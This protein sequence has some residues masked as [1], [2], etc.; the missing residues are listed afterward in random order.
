[1]S[2]SRGTN[3]R[4]SQFLLFVLIGVGATIVFSV[5]VAL[6]MGDFSA[7]GL[8]HVAKIMT[9]M[10][11]APAYIAALITLVKPDLDDAINWS[12]G[13]YYGGAV[14]AGV[15][16][17]FGCDDSP[18]A[19][20]GGYASALLIVYLYV[21]HEKKEEAEKEEHFRKW[22]LEKENERLKEEL[23]QLKEGKDPGAG[24]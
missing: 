18:T 23:R 11:F 24:H 16:W 21:R 19:L 17:K 13:I 9:I 6:L 14:L 15:I 10:F 1:M 7:S 3:N 22:K 4:W 20:I 2:K 5:P 12:C 8:L